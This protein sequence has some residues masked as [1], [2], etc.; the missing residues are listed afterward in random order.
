[1]AEHLRSRHI[2]CEFADPDFCV[3]MLTP[4]SDIP[5]LM[6]LEGA[7]T[8]LKQ[9]TPIC[10]APP[11]LAMPQAALSVREA[12]MRPSVLCPIEEAEGKI[13]ANASIS[14][15]PAIPIAICGE[16]LDRACIDLFRYYGIEQ[17]RVTVE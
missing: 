3:L 11:A 8:H 9:R 10:T 1:M 15:P 7:L 12:L 4:Q 13:L 2:E 5:S 6:F 17:V 16:R 14:C